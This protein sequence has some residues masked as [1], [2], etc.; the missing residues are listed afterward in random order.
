MKLTA[1]QNR[2]SW[3][4]VPPGSREENGRGRVQ[5]WIN[6]LP[7]HMTTENQKNDVTDPITGLMTIENQEA[8]VIDLLPVE[9]EVENIY[10]ADS[11]KF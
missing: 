11:G 6:A 5:T 9:T 1:D 3:A 4:V 8:D 7:D 2:R 10:P